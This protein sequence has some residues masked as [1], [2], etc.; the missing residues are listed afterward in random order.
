MS[1]KA[2]RWNELGAGLGF[3]APNIIGF[4]VFIFLPVFAAFMLSFTEWDASGLAKISF[5]GFLNYAEVVQDPYFWEYL[6]NTF[7]FMAG[8]PLGMAVSLGLALAMNQKL[9]GIVVYRTIYFLPYIS[10]IVAV[11]IL[12]QWI[13]NKNSGL[14]NE[15]LKLLGVSN[16]PM[17][18][19]DKFWARPAVIIMQ[20]WKNA[21][22]NMMIY[23]AALQAI[24]YHLY[25]AADIDG[26]SGWQKFMNI[27]MP[28]LAPTHFFVIVMG[29]IGG[30]Q[31]FAEMFVLTAGGPA[32]A[33]T[34]I[35]YH[36]YNEA[37]RPPIKMGS[38]TAI[39]IILFA[40]TMLFTLVQWRFSKNEAN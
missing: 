17:W 22:Y 35:V 40:L 1:S 10:S 9:K 19:G 13:Y 2:K 39:A 34:T 5:V 15:F 25:E 31:S 7:I 16:P 26:A 28:M 21:G 23:L 3:L 30:F 29:I 24:P 27:T 8:I 32:G 18:L 36:I 20:V 4:L 12:F 14:L 33:T 37:F 38:A 11:A 6:I